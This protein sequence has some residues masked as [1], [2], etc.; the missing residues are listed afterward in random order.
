M[1]GEECVCMCGGVWRGGV[2]GCMY[3]KR[4]CVKGGVCCICGER[5]CVY[6]CVRRKNECV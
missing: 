6:M 2:R 3:G 4:M 5:V 1:K